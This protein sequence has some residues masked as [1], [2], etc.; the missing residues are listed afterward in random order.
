MKYRLDILVAKKKK[1]K[2]S[3]SDPN[4]S[5]DIFKTLSK[6]FPT[7]HATVQCF[8]YYLTFWLCSVFLNYVEKQISVTCIFFL[9]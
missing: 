6:L 9:L 3:V 1:K 5:N 8:M 7:F 2:K 4:L